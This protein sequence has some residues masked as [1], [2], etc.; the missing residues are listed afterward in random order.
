MYNEY[1]D[2]IKK[3]FGE[4]K[5]KNPF[6]EDEAEE[7]VNDDNAEVPKGEKKVIKFKAEIRIE[8]TLE[9]EGG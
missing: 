9:L 8:G 3:F 2:F 7:I 6:F 4:K 5:E 1:D